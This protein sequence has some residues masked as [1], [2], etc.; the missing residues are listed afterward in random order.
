MINYWEKLKSKV[1]NSTRILLSTHRNPDGDGLGSE[2]AFYY[3]L[4]SL[5]KEC[6]IINISSM[7]DNYKFLDPDHIVESYDSEKHSEILKIRL[8][9]R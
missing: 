4:K 5:G 6:R 7:N 9:F 1:D 2:I 3:Y 8:W